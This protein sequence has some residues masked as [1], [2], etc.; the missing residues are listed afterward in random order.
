MVDLTD[1][2]TGGFNLELWNVS[3]TNAGTTV[4]GVNNQLEIVN[5]NNAG[6]WDGLTTKS[7]YDFT[8]A[9]DVSIA[10][11]SS[12]RTASLFIMPTDPQN[13]DPTTAA[14]Y[15][16]IFTNAGDVNFEH[17]VGGS[18]VASGYL[19]NGVNGDVLEFVMPTTGAEV[20]FEVNGIQR[21]SI[22]TFGMSRTCYIAL[23]AYTDTIGHEIHFDTLNATYQAAANASALL[24][25]STN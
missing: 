11:P 15:V 22:P 13:T 19:T 24:L 5:T 2:M 18:I 25:L 14:D 6:G 21:G 17:K 20:R 10:V 16:R 12:N 7:P 8:A 1:L 9:A 4:L 23:I 3:K